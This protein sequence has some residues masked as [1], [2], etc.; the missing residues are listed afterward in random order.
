MVESCEDGVAPPTG[1]GSST[2]PPTQLQPPTPQPPT[3]L[4][5]TPQPTPQG[6]PLESAKQETSDADVEEVRKNFEA[7]SME[8]TEQDIND[9]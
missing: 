8:L 6:A 2:D 5:P 3:P 1:A 4:P 9:F 7:A